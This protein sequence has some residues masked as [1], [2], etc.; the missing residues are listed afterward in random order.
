MLIHIRS[1]TAKAISYLSCGRRT[2]G[3]LLMDGYLCRQP[4][5]APPNKVL[6]GREKSFAIRI[7][8]RWM[9]KNSLDDYQIEIVREG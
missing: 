5:R 8:L 3:H 9:E 6:H 7:D 4:S 2:D 1:A